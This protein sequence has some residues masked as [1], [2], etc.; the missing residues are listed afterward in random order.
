L[1]TGENPFADIEPFMEFSDKVEASWDAT[2]QLILDALWEASEIREIRAIVAGLVHRLGVA[3]ETSEVQDEWIYAAYA[4]TFKAKMLVA[5]QGKPAVLSAVRMPW[6][7][8]AS[9]LAR[10]FIV[11][12]LD[13]AELPNDPFAWSVCWQVLFSPR[14]IRDAAEL[15]LCSRVVLEPGLG[16]SLSLHPGLGDQREQILMLRVLDRLRGRRNPL[17]RGS[18]KRRAQRQLTEKQT[19]RA[20]LNDRLTDLLRDGAGTPAIQIDERINELYG[21]LMPKAPKGESPPEP[22]V[23]SW[24]RALKRQTP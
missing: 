1:A 21:L 18:V 8:D 9:E 3:K 24:I 4:W 5:R 20:Q 7:D 10:D 12:Y 6:S 11:R 15:T 14:E 2:A 23:K 19:L 22:T 17:P 13:R 16:D